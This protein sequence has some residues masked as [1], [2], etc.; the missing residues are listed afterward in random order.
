MTGRTNTDDFFEML[1]RR[2]ITD[3]VIG[4]IARG[5]SR[6]D[7]LLLRLRQYDRRARRERLSTQTRQVI[8]S[9]L[10]LLGE[11]PQTGRVS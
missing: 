6:D 4:G 10:R 3:A 8:A 5:S 1:L 7:R 11:E 2:L 9:A